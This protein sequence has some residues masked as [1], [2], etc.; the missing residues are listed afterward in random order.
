MVAC[1]K[2]E[3]STDKSTGRFKERPQLGMGAASKVGAGSKA[4]CNPPVNP[5][6]PSNQNTPRNRS[7]MRRMALEA[8][9][10][11]LTCLLYRMAGYTYFFEQSPY[12]FP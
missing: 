2:S 7:L 3:K 4:R 8:L 9:L 1:Q 11:L 10:E 5:S 12:T 6:L